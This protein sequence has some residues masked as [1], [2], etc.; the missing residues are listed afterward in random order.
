MCSVTFIIITL[1]QENK[2]ELL[3]CDQKY[4]MEMEKKK[5]SSRK[6]LSV[7]TSEIQREQIQLLKS[8]K[9]IKITLESINEHINKLLV[10]IL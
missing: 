7:A 1:N 8:E 4:S 6:N 5:S 2:K 3:Y 9:E 10:R